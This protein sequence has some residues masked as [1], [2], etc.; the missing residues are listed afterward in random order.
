VT[1]AVLFSCKDA[2]NNRGCVLQFNFYLSTNPLELLAN[3]AL[4]F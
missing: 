4:L 3:K 2:P 1:I